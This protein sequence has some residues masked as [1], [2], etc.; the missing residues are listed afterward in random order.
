MHRPFC[1]CKTV[2]TW[3]VVI[4]KALNMTLVHTKNLTLRPCAPDDRYDFIALERD[5]EVMRHLNGG[6]SI[7]Q[8][9]PDPNAPFLMPRGTEPYVWTARRSVNQAFVGWFCLWPETETVAEIGYRLRRQ[10]WG[11]GFASEGSRALINWGFDTCRYDKIFA[12]TMAI[13]QASRRVMEKA[14][15]KYVRTFHPDWP[16]PIAGSEHGEVIYEVVRADWSIK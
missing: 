13:N 8:E 6:Y 3:D 11:Q 9:E 14:G 7:D 1:V 10:E 2:I 15:L 4:A 12:S 16:E 5:P